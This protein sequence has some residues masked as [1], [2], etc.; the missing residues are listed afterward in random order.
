[1]ADI[2]AIVSDLMTKEDCARLAKSRYA[3]AEGKASE[4]KAR[5]E[6]Y[7]RFLAPPGG[8]QWP[9][10]RALRPQKM[11][12]TSNMI[13]AFVDIEARTLSILPRVTNIPSSKDKDGR[14]HAEIVEDLYMRFL[15]LS[16]WDVWMF[17]L[18]LVKSTYGLSFLKPY[19]NEEDDRPDVHVIE[20]PQNLMVGYGSSDYNVV[21]WAIY[22]YALSP[23]EALRRFKDIEIT[24]PGREKPLEVGIR[25]THDDPLAQRANID[26]TG[27]TT[28]NL[29]SGKVKNQYEEKQVTVWDYWYRHTDGNIYNAILVQGTVAEGPTAHPEMPEVPYIPIESMHEPGTP[30][31]LSTVELLTTVQMGLNRAISHFAQIVA[32]NT[33]VAYQIIGENADS[34]PDGIVPRE[35]EA[36]NPGAG[37]KIE[38]IARPVNNFPISQLIEEYRREAHRITGIPEIMFG[39]L[40]G[41][42]TSGRATTVQVQAAINR[43]HQKRNRLYRGLKQLLLFW[44]YMLKQKNPS[45]TTTT[46]AQAEDGKTGVVSTQIKVGDFIKGSE[47][48]KIIAPEITPRDSIEN[49]Q[50]AINLVNAKLLPLVEAMDMIGVENPE[51][52]I[53]TIE[54][55]RSN[56]RLY[57]G[58]VI[59]FASALQLFQTIQAQQQA[60]TAQAQGQQGDGA[61]MNAEQQAQPTLFEDQAGTMTQ[62]GSPPSPG[63]PPVGG[64]EFQPI[65][66]Q[67]GSDATAMSQILLP[68]TGQVG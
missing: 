64:A 15:E 12:I 11:H 7:H 19:W 18:N 68:R 33:G 55:E 10:D 42:D 17:D 56:M 22:E 52:M 26:P 60:M 35:D 30:E 63:A 57:P 46:N 47:R 20:Q 25:V 65:V 27:V 23:I 13:Q 28:R 38:A 39:A 51:Q 37:N 9:E 40:P 61:R 6:I 53:A 43:L 67:Q 29:P 58:D 45:I 32:D 31:G 66:R 1:M 44:G 24:N 21:D 5:Y 3:Q 34:A 59:S 4:R 41:A 8:D 62:A 16:E 50:N 2:E 49:A 36:I 14:L 48:W 54:K